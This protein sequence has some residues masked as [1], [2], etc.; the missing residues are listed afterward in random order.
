MS[1]GVGELR[2]GTSGYRYKHWRGGF[3]PED[4]PERR[5]FECYAQHFDTVEINNT[6]YWLPEED[7]FRRWRREAP[8]GF[9]YAL[10]FS[11]YG[12]HI[13]HLKDGAQTIASF[14]DAARGLGPALGP[15]LV[16]LPPSW[17]PNPQR[18]EEF[19]AQA[20]ADR[21][22]AVEIRDPRWFTDQVFGIL[23]RHRA[24]LCVHDMIEDHPRDLTADW[25][26]IR[27]HGE[28]Y[29]GNY[30][31][32]YLT[33]EADRIAALL[34]DGRDVYAYFN[35]D[36]QGYAVDNARQLRRYV[37]HKME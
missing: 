13:K 32:Q 12:S 23:R 26:Y 7:I 11:R 20:P 25:T 21:R 30:P 27:F 24:A 15:I 1:A 10:K 31:H 37:A 33:A 17:R 14:L 18:L 34:R 3:Y 8:N 2:I 5:W 19:L 28:D 22:W 16:Q 36:A 29:A 4:L 9:V 35:N 6:F